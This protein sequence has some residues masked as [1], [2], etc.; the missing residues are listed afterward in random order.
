MVLPPPVL[1][2][3]NRMQ[4][5]AQARFSKVYDERVASFLKD[6]Y[7]KRVD[8]RLPHIWLV[9]MKHMSNGNEIRLY[10]YPDRGVITQMTNHVCTHYEQV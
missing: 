7:C 2:N 6:G 9:R 8:T 10:G 5:E 4:M 3:P 1:T